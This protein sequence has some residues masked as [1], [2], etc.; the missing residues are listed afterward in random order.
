VREGKGWVIEGRE[1][2]MGQGEGRKG[3]GREGKGVQRGEGGE[4]R[5]GRRRE[6]YKIHV[7]VFLLQLARVFSVTMG[8]VSGPYVNVM[9]ELIV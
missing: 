4:V 8:P 9:G 1:G 2:M 3:R 7:Y 5:M 6:D